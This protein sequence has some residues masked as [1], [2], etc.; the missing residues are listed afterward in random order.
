[1]K[2]TPMQQAYDLG[3]AAFAR[4]EKCVPIMDKRLAALRKMY[5]MDSTLFHCWMQGFTVANLAAPVAA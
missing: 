5:G 1:M 3:K 2:L 4:G